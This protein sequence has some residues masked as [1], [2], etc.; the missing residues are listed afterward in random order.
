MFPPS[1]VKLAHTLEPQNRTYFESNSA[2]DDDDDDDDDDSYETLRQCQIQE[3]QLVLQQ[4]GLIP[5]AAEPGR[6]PPVTVKREH[7]PVTVKREPKP[8]INLRR[9][10]K[11]KSNSVV[12]NTKILKLRTSTGD[13]LASRPERMTPPPSIIYGGIAGVPVL[14]TWDT[15]AHIGSTHDGGLRVRT[16]SL[17]PAASLCI[18]A[19]D[20]GATTTWQSSLDFGD[21]LTFVSSYGN[22]TFQDRVSGSVQVRHQTFDHRVHQS[23]LLNMEYSTEVRVIRGSKSSS[24]WAPENG[25]PRSSERS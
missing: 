13:F 1:P 7:I 21:R 5:P 24:C 16:T 8:L 25:E 2:D 6:I 11:R 18:Y 23:L 15:K 12:Y 20:L 4:L 22:Y 19:Q 14:R 9:N 3:N 17:A 10:P